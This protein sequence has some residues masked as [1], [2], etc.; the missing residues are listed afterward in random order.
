VIGESASV[1][2][3][4]TAPIGSE[5]S[6]SRVDLIPAVGSRALHRESLRSVSVEGS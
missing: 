2:I 4:M 1:L 3:I 5:T 6:V